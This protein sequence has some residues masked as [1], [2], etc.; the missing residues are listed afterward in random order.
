VNAGR[1]PTRLEV[2]PQPRAMRVSDAARFSER[3]VANREISSP[4]GKARVDAF[5]LLLSDVENNA[6]TNVPRGIIDVN[7]VQKETGR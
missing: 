4:A 6:N 1:L 2:M 7:L 3:R 5:W